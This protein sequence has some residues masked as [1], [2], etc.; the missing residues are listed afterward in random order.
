[1]PQLSSN[2]QQH[3]FATNGSP[4]I[5]ELIADK[6]ASSILF[7][8]QIR[9]WFN[10]QSL[11][12]KVL[13]T[14]GCILLA[15]AGILFIVFHSYLINQ[16]INLSDKWHDL[17]YGRV[18]IFA[19]V[20]TVSF[21]PLI[22]FTAL[23]MLTGMVYGFP[24]GWPLLAFASVSGCTAS[25]LVFRYLLQNQATRLVQYN[26]KFRA[27]AEVL[28]EDSSLLLLCLIR[29]CPLPYSLSNGALAAVPELPLL[30]YFL[31]TFITSPKLFIH[32]FVG[33][34]LK[35]L[36]SDKSSGMSKVVDV[37]S[38]AIT[39]G[40]ASLA[41]YLIYVKMQQKLASFHQRG[42]IHDDVLVFGN[43]ADEL[44]I[45]SHNEIEL[46]STDFDTDNFLIDDDEEDQ[47]EESVTSDTR[48]QSSQKSQNTAKSQKSREHI[49]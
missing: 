27:F 36:G 47:D 7:S 9:T 14:A 24:Q 25:F 15:I 32:L 33:S 1:M 38:I 13:V 20:F 43:F 30:T 26:E 34:K 23:S 18:I 40:A 17:K 41:T 42:V 11:I 49:Q 37:I 31:A 46:N 21:P 45:G 4:S 10:E 35:D 19:L 48:S 8:N 28:H 22:G 3:Q 44:E 6:V 16:L 2:D 5:R 12:K 39:A 29:L